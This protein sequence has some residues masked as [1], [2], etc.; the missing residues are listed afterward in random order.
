MSSPP[1]LP[2]SLIVITYNEAADIARCLDSVSFA[3]EKIV[4]DCG[5]D[6]DTR[7]IA[8]AHGARVVDQPWLGFGAQRNFASALASNDWILSLDADEALTP[9]LASALERGLPPLLASNLAVGVLYRTAWF[10]GKPLRWYRLMVRERKPRIYHRQ[11][12]RWSEARVHESLQYSGGEATFQPPFMHYLN[13]TLVHH[14]LKYL[15]Y[16]ELKALDWRERGRGTRPYAWPLVFILTFIKDYLLRLAVLDGARGWVA[17]YMAAH[18]AV[19]KRVRY[20][21]MRHFERSIE[22]ADAELRAHRLQR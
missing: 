14:E 17:A 8:A 6:D 11:R 4:V 5:S 3:D 16:A 15:R 22:L 19:Y 2:I 10:M 13:P 18:Y 7:R 1:K 21:E 12:A 20:Y 9:E